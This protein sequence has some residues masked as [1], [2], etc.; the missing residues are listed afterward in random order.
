M[1]KIYKQVLIL[2]LGLFSTTFAIGQDFDEL[3]KKSVDDAEYVFKG[4]FAPMLKAAGSGIN[5]G[6]YNTAKPHKIAG[7][8]IT[9]SLSMISIP[10][11]DKSFTVDNNAMTTLK[12]EIDGDGNPVAFN[13][14]GNIPTAFGGTKAPQFDFDDPTTPG[15]Q[16]D[17]DDAATNSPGVNGAPGIGLADFP[18]KRMPF[19]IANVGIGLPKG[20]EL[21]IRWTPKVDLGGEG[22]FKLI[23]FGLMHDIKQYIPGIKMLPFDLSG[24]VTYSKM[25]L[26]LNLNDDASQRGEFSIKGTTIQALISKKISVITPYAA[27]GYGISNTTLKAAGNYDWNEDGDSNDVRE[28]DPFTL[29]GKNSGPRI[30][31]GLRLKLAI[32]T[33]H[34]D[35]TV[36]KYSTF[37]AGFGLSVR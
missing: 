31:T 16:T 6:W 32:F 26:V 35:Y 22:S 25:D 5:Q 2:S 37:T 3:M 30:T 27:I 1:N 24:L 34:A 21:K 4:Y 9:T 29:E 7:I 15:D 12:L 20:I 23:G 13:G 28:K 11:S 10:A 14:T 33:F 18:L 17:L 8:D 19:P 36:Q